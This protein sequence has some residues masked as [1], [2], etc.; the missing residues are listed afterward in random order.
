MKSQSVFGGLL[1]LAMH[2]KISGFHSLASAGKSKI[3]IR[4]VTESQC[5]GIL[6]DYL[7]DVASN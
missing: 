3:H 2:P 6:P 4:T 7:V 1:L 5:S